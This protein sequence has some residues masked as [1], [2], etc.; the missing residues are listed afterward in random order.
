MLRNDW[1]QLA[2]RPAARACRCD[3]RHARPYAR[4]PAGRAAQTD[5]SD[6]IVRDVVHF[7]AKSVE[8]GHPSR[9]GLG[10]RTKASARFDALLR[11]MA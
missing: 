5:G 7:T 11:V 8:R 10:R 9:F 2:K 1:L 4:L 3:R 6:F